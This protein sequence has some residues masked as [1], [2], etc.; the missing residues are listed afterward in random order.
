MNGGG[1]TPPPFPPRLARRPAH[2]Y[3]LRRGARLAAGRPAH[4]YPLR[5]GAR[6]AARR[7]AHAYPL[8]RGAR[9][10]ARRPAHAYSLRRG[11]RLAARRPAHAYSLR[12]GA[13]LAARRPAHAYSLRRDAFAGRPARAYYLRR[14]HRESTRVSSLIFAGMSAARTRPSPTRIAWAPATTTR[15]T[16]AAVKKPL[17]LTTIGPGGIS[18]RSS[19]VVLMRVSKVARSRLLIP[20]MRLPTASA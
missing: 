20:T 10:A 13:R 5:R 11:A 16:S 15:R 14:V 18:G 7:P 2:A 17:S 19:S 6:L 8:R 3:P 9:L 4:A 12:R 1:G